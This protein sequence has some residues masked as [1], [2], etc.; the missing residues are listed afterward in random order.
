MKILINTPNYKNPSSG[1]VASYYYGMLG[2]WNESVKYNIVGRRKGFSG[3]VW[4]P[5]DILVFIIKLLLWRPN[6]VVVN[7]SLFQNALRRDFTFLNVAKLLR[8]PVVVLIHG[9]DLEVSQT[10]DSKWV[11]RNLN[12][13]NLVLVLANQ[14]RD[15]LKRWG[16]T[17]PIE[18]TTTKVEDRM[19]DGFNINI[20]K[21]EIRNILFLSRMV[22]GKG[23]YE[24]IDTFEI[25]KRENPYIKLT[26]VGS[27]E[28][29]DNLKSYVDG[30]NIKDV[31]FT[32]PLSGES[33]LNAYREADFFFFPT[34]YGE[35]M[36]TVVLEAMAFG[37]PVLTRKV[38][39][40]V[41]FF[42]DGKMGCITD[43]VRPDEFAKM[44]D[45]Y[46]RNRN[47]TLQTSLYNHKYALD[48]FMASKVGIR[49]E[50]LIK[51]YTPKC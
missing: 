15:I 31:S 43:S 40:L 12:K 44:I 32:G 38:G 22:K 29:L 16:V 42:E 27:G 5:W 30:K 4:L 2:Y 37:L 35:G 36:P 49:I 19:L 20:R 34:N 51:K 48:H 3:A 28:E 11:K 25:I 8:F 10:I 26:M 50:T 24:T 9:F 47:L 21:G 7:P 41:D 45:P 33:R 23:V 17:A 6:V 14:F 39:G 18:L 46:I 1:G 13:A